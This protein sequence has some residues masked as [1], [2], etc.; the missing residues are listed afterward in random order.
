MDRPSTSVSKF[1]IHVHMVTRAE[2]DLDVFI[3]H[4]LDERCAREAQQYRSNFNDKE[5]ERLP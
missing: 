5:Y 3:Q 1:N 2:A 4:T